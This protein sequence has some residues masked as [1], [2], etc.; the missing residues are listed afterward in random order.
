VE[1]TRPAQRDPHRQTGG[2]RA[3]EHGDLFVAGQLDEPVADRE[4]R[5]VAAAPTGAHQELV[6]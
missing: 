4:Q 5:Q 1:R 2:V 3:G 6:M